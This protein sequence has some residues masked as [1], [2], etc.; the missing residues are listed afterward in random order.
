MPDEKVPALY[1][2]WQN[3]VIMPGIHIGDGAIIGAN[4]VVASNIAPY[5]INEEYLKLRNEI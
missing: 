3:A 4:A 1:D 5:T 2:C